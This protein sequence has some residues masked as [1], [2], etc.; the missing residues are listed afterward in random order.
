MIYKVF[1]NAIRNIQL[2]L[3]LESI[4]YDKVQRLSEKRNK[5]ASV[6]KI[7]VFLNRLL[8]MDLYSCIYSG[9]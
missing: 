1:W 7:K 3:T 5:N 8:G 6:L 9:K 4:L 2:V